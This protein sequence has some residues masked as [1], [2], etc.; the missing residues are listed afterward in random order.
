[1]W[2]NKNPAK[3][4]HLDATMDE[5]IPRASPCATHANQGKS[6]PSGGDARREG[7]N[8]GGKHTRLENVLHC[9]KFYK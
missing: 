8:E 3:T 4:H 5:P 2:R 7:V 1:M 6:M 9:S